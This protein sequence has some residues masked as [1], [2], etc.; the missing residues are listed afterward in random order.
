MMQNRMCCRGTQAES[1][2]PVSQERI[3][4]MRTVCMDGESG[5]VLPPAVPSSGGTFGLHRRW[6]LGENFP[7]P[8]PART[9]VHNRK[10]QLRYKKAELETNL[11]KSGK[12]KSLVPQK[13][14]SLEKADHLNY[15]HIYLAHLIPWPTRCWP[16]RRVR[17]LPLH[18]GEEARE[19]AFLSVTN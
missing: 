15:R 5:A 16:E 1:E 9:Y 13:R 14:N 3:C 4:A 10:L 7:L 6:L 18:D 8:L 19:E 12:Y 17:R 11:E 2:Q